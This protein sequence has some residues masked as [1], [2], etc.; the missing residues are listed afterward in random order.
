M[1]EQQNEEMQVSKGGWIALGLFAGV[2]GTV[3]VGLIALAVVVG[4]SGGPD[5]S[6][7]QSTPTPTVAVA[8][9]LAAA[10]PATP[11]G[12][13]TALDGDAAN[14]EAI[15][16]SSCSACHAAGAVGVPGLG[17]SLV[18][19]DF[20]NGLA[21]SDLVAFISVGRDPSDPANTTGVGMPP[22]GG[23]PSLTDA[24]LADIVA[25]IRSLN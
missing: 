22:K 2:A 21:D 14:G 18:G 3:A 6:D 20:V 19:S 25:Y 23:N 11:S 10:V 12:S 24:D 1:A 13:G 17:K 5:A 9:T 15:Y 4:S 16:T 8:T 7:A